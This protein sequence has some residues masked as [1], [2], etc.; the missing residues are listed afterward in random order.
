MYILSTK[1]KAVSMALTLMLVTLIGCAS[2]TNKEMT[3]ESVEATSATP[4][5][6]L[7]T[8]LNG[9]L[10]EHVFLAAD[11]TGAALGGRQAEFEA[12]AAALDGNSIDLANAN[13]SVYGPEAGEAFLPLWRKHIG[14]VVDYTT[15][16]ATNDKAKQDQA[17]ANLIQYS[18]D[19][20]A[21]INS[22]SPSLPVDVVAELVKGHILTLKEV[23]DAQAAGDYGKAYTSL[24]TA[25]AHMPMIADAHAGA[26][27]KQ[28]PDKFPGSTDSSAATLR[29]NLNLLLR[30]HVFLAASATGAALGGRQAEF[31]AA[32]AALD[33]NSVD[34]AKAIGS[35]YGA[36]AGEAFLPLWRKHIG[37]VVDYTTGVATKDQAKQEKAVAD[38]V[39]YTQD[40]GAFLNSASPALPTDVVADL[41]KTHVLTLKTVIDAQAGGDQAKA[42]SDLRTA[43]SHMQ[44]IGDP[45]AETIVKQFPNNFAMK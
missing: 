35:V 13:G 2:A 11:A 21:F 33:A 25:A 22:A 8:K 6:A 10:Q 9:L 3:K 19:F 15:G 36:E 24:R 38:L 31:E 45:L 30:E 40:F 41:V 14:F 26:I 4:A 42:Y 20:A 29:S 7:R 44:M 43:A 18:Q 17:V 28:F 39:Q 5:A 37:F 32:A 34:V 23:I 27:A 12:A 16:V 1:L